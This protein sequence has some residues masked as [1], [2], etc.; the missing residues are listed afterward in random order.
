VLGRPT[1]LIGL[2]AS[3][4]GSQPVVCEVRAFAVEP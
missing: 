3:N 2:F 4:S 1:G